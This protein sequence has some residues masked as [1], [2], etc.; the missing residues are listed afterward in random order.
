MQKRAIR[1]I[2]NAGYWNHTNVLF[3]KM[4]AI[5]FQY[6][7]KFKTAQIMNKARNKILVKEICKMFVEREGEY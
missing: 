7:V 4:Q 1:L 6:F 2:N 5:Q 3:M